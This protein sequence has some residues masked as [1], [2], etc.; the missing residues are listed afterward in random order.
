ML[1]DVREYNTFLY[2]FQGLCKIQYQQ[3]VDMFILFMA[4]DTQGVALSEPALCLSGTTSL[5]PP[6]SLEDCEGA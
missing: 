5:L 2:S 3:N 6:F 1:K 4:E